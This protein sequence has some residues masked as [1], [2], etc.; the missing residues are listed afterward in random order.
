MVWTTAFW[1]ASIRGVVED[2]GSEAA[3]AT[4]RFCS[5]ATCYSSRPNMERS[6]SSIR[7]RTSIEK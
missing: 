4:V 1:S 3:T 7:Y 2:A 5:S 6:F